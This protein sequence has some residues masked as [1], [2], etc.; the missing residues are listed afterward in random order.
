MSFPG[1]SESYP[2][3]KGDLDYSAR[4]DLGDA[5]LALQVCADNVGYS[6]INIKN[7]V[8]TDGKISLEEAIFVLRKISGL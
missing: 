4:T 2:S 3:V 8:N 7:E 6:D 1:D 5:I